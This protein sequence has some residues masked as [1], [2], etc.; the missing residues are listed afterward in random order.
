MAAMK[1]FRAAGVG[2]WSTENEKFS[3]STLVV[4]VGEI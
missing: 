4:S 2:D 1:G 3:R